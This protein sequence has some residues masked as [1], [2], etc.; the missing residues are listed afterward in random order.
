[1]TCPAF[2]G[3]GGWEVLLVLAV[4]LVIFGPR[5]VPEFARGLGRLSA[6]IQD[7]NRE[8]QRE[9]S[10]SIEEPPPGGEAD[11][12][13][14]EAAELAYREAHAAAPAGDEEAAPAAGGA[15]TAGEG[16]EEGPAPGAGPAD[17]DGS[18]V[19]PD[20]APRDQR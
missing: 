17:G 20:G 1:M 6:R 19:P 7:A 11:R 4:A 18:A 16:D 3:V 13:A 5:K 10:R 14:A 2:A 12:R 9:L 15:A 8:L